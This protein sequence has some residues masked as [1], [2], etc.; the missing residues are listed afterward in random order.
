LVEPETAAWLVASLS[1]GR[2]TRTTGMIVRAVLQEARHREEPLLGF[3][4][5]SPNALRREKPDGVL[6]WLLECVEDL[7]VQEFV[8]QTFPSRRC[9][10]SRPPRSDPARPTRLPAAT[11]RRPPQACAASFPSDLPSVGPQ[12]IPQGGPPH[13]GRITRPHRCQRVRAGPL[14]PCPARRDAWLAAGRLAT[15]TSA[16]LGGPRRRRGS[17]ATSTPPKASL[18]ASVVPPA[19]G[20]RQLGKGGAAAPNVVSSFVAGPQREMLIRRIQSAAYQALTG[21][22]SGKQQ[23]PQ[24]QLSA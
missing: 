4:L 23:N 1:C 13:R 22:S 19:Q 18:K 9:R 14:R 10:G 2:P 20:D 6:Q 24:G 5:S 16:A 3:A 11:W 17:V 8:P 12:A 15:T 21:T 7:A